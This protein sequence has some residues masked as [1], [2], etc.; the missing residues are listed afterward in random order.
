MPSLERVA[1][2]QPP[3][4]HRCRVV[5]HRTQALTDPAVPTAGE[6][7]GDDLSPTWRSGSARRSGRRSS[8]SARRRR[9]SLDSFGRANSGS[10]VQRSQN[11]QHGHVSRMAVPIR[12]RALS[13][14]RLASALVANVPGPPSDPRDAE[15]LPG[16]R[17]RRPAPASDRREPV[18]LTPP[19]RVPTPRRSPQM[20]RK[21][22]VRRPQVTDGIPSATIRS[23]VAMLTPMI[24]ASS[25]GRRS[26]RALRVARRLLGIS[27]FGFYPLTRLYDRE[28]PK[29][30]TDFALG[31]RNNQSLPH[32]RCDEPPWRRR[33]IAA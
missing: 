27:G 26:A 4:L 17:D 7:V 22:R 23:T 24:A 19:S 5:E 33:R 18:T 3:G 8:W 31:S 9:I 13:R 25:R 11:P 10:V 16:R 15:V 14:A 6:P 2:D 12:S 1:V 20:A 32:V 21:R 30:A 29:T 28:R